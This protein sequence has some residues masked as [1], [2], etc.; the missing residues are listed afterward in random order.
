V[1]SHRMRTTLGTKYT[2]KRKPF[3]VRLQGK[4]VSILLIMLFTTF[5]NYAMQPYVSVVKIEPLD[6]VFE[7]VALIALFPLSTISSMHH[8]CRHTLLMTAKLL[9]QWK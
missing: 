8:T 4:R 6:N 5:H 7:V 3:S 2:R 1:G 9:A